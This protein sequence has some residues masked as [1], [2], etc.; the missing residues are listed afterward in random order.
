MKYKSNYIPPGNSINENMKKYLRNKNSKQLLL[1]PPW[2]ICQEI[3]ENDADYME[4]FICNLGDAID[5]IITQ[6]KTAPWFL[7]TT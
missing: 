7:L 6:I 3:D 1:Y 2:P 5:H 4:L